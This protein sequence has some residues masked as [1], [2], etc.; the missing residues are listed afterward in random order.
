MAAQVESQLLG[1]VRDRRRL[2]PAVARACELCEGIVGALD[3][4]GVVL[5]VI[6]AHRLAANRRLE[7]VV[8]IW[9]GRKR[10]GSILCHR[11]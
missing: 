6:Q 2:D 5:V 4:R 11:G 1:K 7:G 8:G 3:I 9:Q 10:I